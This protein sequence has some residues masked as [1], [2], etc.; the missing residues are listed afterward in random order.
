MPNGSIVKAPQR[1]EK[2]RETDEMNGNVD[3]DNQLTGAVIGAAIDVHREL[4][5]GKCESAY[6]K[7]ISIRLNELGVSHCCQ[8]RIPIVYRDQL[9]DCDLRVD[10]FVDGRLPV[11]LKVVESLLPIHEAQ[12]LTYMRLEAQRLGLLINF[13]VTTLTEGI[14]RRVLTAVPEISDAEIDRRGFDALSGRIFGA[15]AM[16]YLTM[17]RG[18]LR[19]VYHACLCQEFRLSELPFSADHGY[20]LSYRNLSLGLQENVPI[21]VDGR[22]PLFIGSSREITDVQQATLYSCLKQGGWD[23]GF[24]V[25]FNA[26]S[27]GQGVRRITC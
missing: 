18:L 23:Y 11:E 6:E 10:L 19:S 2:R 5:P 20:D 14:K 24:I 17:G 3:Q 26:P 7:A 15:V 25:N 16:V 22:V 12:L 21:L 1:W 8:K 4:G 13:H 27:L 9:V